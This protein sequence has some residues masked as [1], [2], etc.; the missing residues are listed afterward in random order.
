MDVTHITIPALWFIGAYFISI[1]V[2]IGAYLSSDPVL[3]RVTIIPHTIAILS[4]IA[5]ITYYVFLR[6]REIYGVLLPQLALLLYIVSNIMFTLTIYAHHG[7]TMFKTL[8]KVVAAIK[9]WTTSR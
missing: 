2:T 8:R 5:A 4:A 7:I 1:A 9:Q 6:D 3:R